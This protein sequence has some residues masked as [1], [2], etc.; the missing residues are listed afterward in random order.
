MPKRLSQQ[1]IEQIKELHSLGL[2][3]V[4]IARRVGKTQNCISGIL[5]RHYPGYISQRAI[6]PPET[7][8]KII[9]MYRT[10]QG[11]NEIKNSLEIKDYIIVQCLKREGI[12][13]GTRSKQIAPNSLIKKID[14]AV[15]YLL[16]QY[17]DGVSIK[18]LAY[19][20]NITEAMVYNRIKK[21]PSYAP[22]RTRLKSAVKDRIQKV[23]ADIDY[24]L[25]QYANGVEL[26]QL[27][28][29]YNVSP[30]VIYS[31]LKI[32]PCYKKRSRHQ[33]EKD[34]R[35]DDFLDLYNNQGWS[36]QK[37]ADHYQIDRKKV[38]R[39]LRTHPDFIPRQPQSNHS[40]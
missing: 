13:E 11:V 38:S 24:L 22:I 20:Y 7:K 5:K 17:T 40:D 33:L 36:V 2:T 35:I 15:D 10:G 8:I 32:H 12:Y 9:E 19:T 30:S 34:E 14:K 25:E 28:K 26:K 23:E 29:Q 27:A 31:R 1:Q 37:I 18:E 6:I 3:Q 4:E 16:E 21:H 39:R